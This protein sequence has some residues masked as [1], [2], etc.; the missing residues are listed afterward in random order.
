MKKN[1]E[2]VWQVCRDTCDDIPKM[3]GKIPSTG[4]ALELLLLV[5]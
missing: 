5:S 3:C 1:K 4:E 2:G